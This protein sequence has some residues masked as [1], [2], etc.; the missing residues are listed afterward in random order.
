MIVKPRIKPFIKQM[1]KYNTI[2][3][4]FFSHWGKGE[5][6]RLRCKSDSLCMPRT[7]KEL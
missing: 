6:G 4:I 3:T 7:V 2:I 1:T 5:L